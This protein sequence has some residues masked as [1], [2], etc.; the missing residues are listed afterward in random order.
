[1]FDRMKKSL[2]LK[3]ETKGHRLGGSNPEPAPAAAASGASAAPEFDIRFEEQS[4]GLTVAETDGHSVVREVIAGS[5]ADKKGIRPGDRIV[6]LEGNVITSHNDFVAMVGAFPRP[7]TMRFSRK[8]SVSSGGGKGTSG[9]MFGALKGLT[10]SS[11]TTNRSSGS[12]GSFYKAP[13]PAAAPKKPLS[14]AEKEERRKMMVQAAKDRE[15]QWDRRLKDSKKAKD[16]AGKKE[17][18]DGKPIYDHSAAASVGNSN[19]ETQRMVCHVLILKISMKHCY[20][21]QTVPSSSPFLRHH[22]RIAL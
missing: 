9:S 6:S 5:S 7:F 20:F 1:M 8:P 3:Q 12:G 10:G 14:E 4:L 16:L 15:Q 17:G 11:S 22:V 18:T 21:F 13:A 19:P 2:G